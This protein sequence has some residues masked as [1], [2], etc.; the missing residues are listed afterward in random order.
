MGNELIFKKIARFSRE[1]PKEND[2]L[3]ERFKSRRD[4]FIC[5]GEF[6]SSRAVFG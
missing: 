3:F 4:L 5:G 6:E 1:K 2:N